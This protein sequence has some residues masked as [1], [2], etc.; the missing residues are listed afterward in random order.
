[1]SRSWQDLQASGSEA[2]D[3]PTLSRFKAEVGDPAHQTTWEHIAELAVIC[4]WAPRY[5]EEVF[6]VKGDNLGALNNASRL[7]GKG[8]LLAVSRELAWRRAAWRL[9]PVYSHLPSEL[10]TWA[11]DLSRLMA[12]NRHALPAGL[13]KVPRCAGP[14]VERLWEA[15]LSEPPVTRKSRR[16]RAGR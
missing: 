11:D 6:T 13:R 9:R 12:P 2:W 5:T 15:W 16:G 7:K 4:L 8:P 1:M 3:Q 14:E 10:N